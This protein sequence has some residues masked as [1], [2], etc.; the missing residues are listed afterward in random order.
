MQAKI[1]TSKIEVLVEKLEDKKYKNILLFF[2]GGLTYNEIFV[3][4]KIARKYDKKIFIITTNMI[5]S[6]SFYN[7]FKNL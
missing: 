4:N 2:I 7:M 1:D 3:I 5:N 6:N